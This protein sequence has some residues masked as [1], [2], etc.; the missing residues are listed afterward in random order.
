LGARMSPGDHPGRLTARSH[1]SVSPVIPHN[2]RQ[3]IPPPKKGGSRATSVPQ[4]TCRGRPSEFCGKGLNFTCSSRSPLQTI[5]TCCM[6]GA[7]AGGAW[8]A[9]RTFFSGRKFLCF[10]CRCCAFAFFCLL[11]LQRPPPPHSLQWWHVT[12]CAPSSSPNEMSAAEPEAHT[13]AEL[14]PLTLHWTTCSS[15]L[16]GRR[17]AAAS[18]VSRPPPSPNSK[19]APTACNLALG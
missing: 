14:S 19:T 18:D 5:I 17:G 6:D 1:A 16:V 9:H 4:E 2:P 13:H 15:T 10:M 12:G 7:H 11:G 8:Q 3:N